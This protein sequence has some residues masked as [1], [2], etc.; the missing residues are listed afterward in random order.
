MNILFPTWKSFGVEDIKETF[1]ELGHKVSLYEKE[2]KNY[3]IDPRYKSEI[4]KYIKEN[5]ID[6]VFTSNYYPVISDGC[7]DLKI[8]YLSWCYD[9]PLILTYSK[10]VFNEVNRIFIFDS[11]MVQELRNLG[12]K[13]V[14]YMPMAVNEKRLA[15]L[16][17][18]PQDRK[19]VESDVS[20]VGR[21]YTEEHN[22]YDRMEPKLDDYTKGYLEGIM[23]SQR[24][25]YGYT[26]IEE[27]LTPDIVEK[28]MAAMPV[29]VQENGMESIEY[30]YA[31]YFLCRKMTQLDRTEIFSYLGEKL[32][33]IKL[34]NG[35][36]IAPMKLYTSEPT[37][38]LKG[39]KNMGEVHYMYEMP[40]VFKYSKINLNITLR[41]IRNGIP[42]RAMDIMGAGGFLLTNY[43]NDFAMHFVDGEDYV[44]YSDRKA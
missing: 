30:I 10:S 18:S 13:N 8:P 6:A 29:K 28:M 34:E 14:W 43:Q 40:L 21:L 37:P 27:L 41:S 16:S 44:S 23:G 9:S 26:F 4:K 36:N 39:I 25:I 5:D 15:D 7:N 1:E 24:M 2:P 12:V 31:N 17:I 42:L 22:L 11:L 3:R 35:R 38:Q 32:H 33:K 20:F 19:I